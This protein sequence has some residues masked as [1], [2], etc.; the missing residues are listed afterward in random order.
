[1][2]KCDIEYNENTDEFESDCGGVFALY[3]EQSPH[4]H[5]YKFCPFCGGKAIDAAPFDWSQLKAFPAGT[6]FAKDKGGEW[7]AFVESPTFR[8]NALWYKSS[9]DIELNCFELNND[10]NWPDVEPADSLMQ[11]P[12]GV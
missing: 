8:S 5:G 9:E 10:I 7:W 2:K 4:D 3:A 6:W 11:K 12:E 1:M